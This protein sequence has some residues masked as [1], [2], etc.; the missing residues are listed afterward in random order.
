MFSIQNYRAFRKCP[1]IPCKLVG[2]AT[3]S[4]IVKLVKLKNEEKARKVGKSSLRS[5]V[6]QNSG[7]RAVTNIPAYVGLTATI[8]S[9]QRK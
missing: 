7:N 4:E 5:V 9:E 1:A 2:L 3:V 6:K 8:I